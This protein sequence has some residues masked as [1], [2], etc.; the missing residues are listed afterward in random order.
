MK[1]LC[2]LSFFMLYFPLQAQFQYDFQW[3]LENYTLMDFRNNE[4]EISSITPPAFLGPGSF[5]SS[6]CSE[7]G[8]LIFYSGGCFILNS[9]NQIMVNGDSINS[10]FSHSV[11]CGAN[12]FPVPQ[13]IISVPL[14]G[15]NEQYLVFNLDLNLL[16]EGGILPVPQ[17]LFSHNIDMQLDSGLGEVVEKKNIIIMDTLARGYLQAVK[18]YNGIDWWIVTPEWNSN[19]YYLSRVSSTGVSIPQKQCIGKIW[20]NEDGGGQASFSPDGS[21]YARVE[22]ENGLLLFEFD[23]DNGEFV[24]FLE[25]SYPQDEDYFRGAAFSS[26]S[27]FLYISA[28]SKLWQFDLESDNIQESLQLAGEIDF[29]QVE[30]GMGSLYQAKLAPNGK[31]YIASPGAH[32]FLSVINRPNCPGIL[33]DFQ[34]HSVE[35]PINNF[36]GLPNTP[37]FNIPN[38]DIECDSIVS[39]TN[40]WD[41]KIEFNIFPNPVTYYLNVHIGTTD[42][43]RF[44]IVDLIG[45]EVVSGE[46]KPDRTSINISDLNS[47]IYF[48][49]VTDQGSINTVIKKIIKI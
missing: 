4:L 22:G 43:S 19:C 7:S 47:G 23:N 39:I 3:V 46:L 15:V 26:N 30:P 24:D 5:T 29:T 11:F 34:A 25:L 12:Y 10:D 27:R 33:C 41:E 36:G 48:I 35:L 38:T 45:K 1:N 40:E 14:L 18:H 28:T 21:K 16:D 44:R 49:S 13:G 8:D 37:H 6:M 9:E 20:N 42:Y 32:T 31:I 2:V 17:H